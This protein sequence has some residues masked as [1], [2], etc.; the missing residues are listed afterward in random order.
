MSFQSVP[1]VVCIQDRIHRILNLEDNH[2]TH[3]KKDCNDYG[4]SRGAKL[5]QVIELV[6]GNRI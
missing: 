2:H 6:S 4:I 1:K 5:F 3:A